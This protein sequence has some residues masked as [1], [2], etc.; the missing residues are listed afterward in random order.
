[1]QKFYPLESFCQLST[2][3]SSSNKSGK[4][5]QIFA[6]RLWQAWATAARWT[7]W[8]PPGRSSGCGSAW[9]KTRRCRRS[10]LWCCDPACASTAHEAGEKDSQGARMKG[11]RERGGNVRARW[12]CK[13][14]ACDFLSASLLVIQPVMPYIHRRVTP[15]Q[16]VWSSGHCCS[17]S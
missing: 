9:L 3:L 17:L 10:A 16:S 8:T 6:S 5:N 14:T 12:R 1:M 11:T 4:K 7:G 15:L 13:E 2:S